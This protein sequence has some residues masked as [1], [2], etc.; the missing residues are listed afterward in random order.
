MACV[1]AESNQ[2]QRNQRS[3]VRSHI[4]DNQLK[5]KKKNL[6]EGSS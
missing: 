4:L 3:C 1:P 6:G 2:A 5:Q